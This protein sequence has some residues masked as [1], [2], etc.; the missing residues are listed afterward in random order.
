MWKA[1]LR[2]RRAGPALPRAAADARHGIVRRPPTTSAP[3]GGAASERWRMSGCLSGSGAA[4]SATPCRA[5]SLRPAG[6]PPGRPGAAPVRRRGARS[7]VGRRPVLPA[8]L[9][10]RGVL[11]VRHRRVY[12]RRVVGWQLAGHMSTTL[13]L[14]A[15]R[16]ALGQRRSGADVASSTA[17]RPSSSP[18]ASGAA[19]HSSSSPSSS[20]S[21]G[22][23]TTASTKPSPTFHQPRWRPSTLPCRR[24]ISLSK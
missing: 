15:P 5:A 17:S 23:T 19:A 24:P 21:A 8:L 18:T 2:R 3:A 4:W 7:S 12:S 22:S 16:M 11:R 13:V 20:T 6:E 1:L 9:G 10:G 14:D